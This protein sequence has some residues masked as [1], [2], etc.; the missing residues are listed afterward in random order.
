MIPL[1]IPKFAT[2]WLPALAVSA[3]VQPAPRLADAFLIPVAGVQVPLL[4]AALGLLG[5]LMARPLAKRRETVGWP[6]FLL[7]TAIM[8]IVVE[9]WIVESRPGALFAFVIAIGLG[10]SGYSLIELI[11]SQI[12]EFVKRI[13]AVPTAKLGL[14]ATPAPSETP[15]PQEDQV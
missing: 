15:D 3:T 12:G 13:V 8:L 9:L 1:S 5:V 6:G 11:G 10:F 4:T 7:V 14:S 2:A